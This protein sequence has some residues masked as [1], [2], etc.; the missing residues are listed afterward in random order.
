MNY[1]VNC[2]SYLGLSF[3]FDRSRPEIFSGKCA[4]VR[5][6]FFSVKRHFDDA[7]SLL[8]WQC[9]VEQFAVPYCFFPS[10]LP[11]RAQQNNRPLRGSDPDASIAACTALID[12]GK[13]DNENQAVAY[14]NR[15]IAH[16]TKNEQT[17]AIAD[18]NQAIQ[19]EP[20][21]AGA[22]SNRANAD[23][24]RG[25]FDR[26]MADDNRAIQ[27]KPDDS[28]AYNYRGAAYA[29]MGQFET[30]IAD[31]DRAIQLK[32]ENTVRFEQPRQRQP[33]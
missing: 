1:E 32:P 18:F 27:L 20:D 7:T 16:S 33:T 23:A 29:A 22:F 31:F 5:C 26:A 28:D 24:A 11:R 15:G 9:C 10:Q 25:D 4:N 19:L 30:A 6:G 3:S 13:E 17:Q 21:Y 2:R 8:G 12:S 14:N